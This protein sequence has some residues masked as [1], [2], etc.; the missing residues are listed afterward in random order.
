MKPATRRHFWRLAAIVCLLAATAPAAAQEDLFAG[1]AHAVW[2]VR[3]AAD[4]K[5]VDVLARPAGEKWKL[6]EIGFQGKP[7]GIVTLGRSMR[8]LFGSGDHVAFHLNG[9]PPTNERSAEDANWPGG[10]LPLVM[11]E[12]T[13]FA[14][15][16]T[17]SILAVVAGRGVGQAPRP[18]TAPAAAT[19]PTW[20]A[21]APA[22]AAAARRNKRLLTAAV[23]QFAEGEWSQ[24]PPP[25]VLI[26]R[27]RRVF[28]AAVDSEFYVLLPDHETGWN[29]LIVLAD[30]K[31]RDVALD[32]KAAMLK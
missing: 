32:D 24:L 12:A 2:L 16:N 3:R 21:I 19:A 9:Q 31:W 30:G 29:K 7:T 25:G 17:P 27:G 26:E 4:G 10:V 18:R 1:N 8:A 15:P 20:P 13:G 22:N 6:I 28:A 14:A 11:C 5:G 23:F